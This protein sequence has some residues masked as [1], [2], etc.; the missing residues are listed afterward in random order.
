MKL[1]LVVA[2]MAAVAACGA[3]AAYPT[4]KP[5]LVSA[6]QEFKEGRQSRL[7]AG[8]VG[9]WNCRYEGRDA[10][11]IWTQ[12]D[13]YI[14]RC[15]SATVCQ[16]EYKSTTYIGRFQ[17]KGRQVSFLYKDWNGVDVFFTHPDGNDW[18]AMPTRANDYGGSVKNPMRYQDAVKLHVTSKHRGVSTKWTCNRAP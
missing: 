7:P 12:M 3:A 16:R 4:N 14:E 17:D 5:V 8:F 11:M 1:R 10:T 2:T 18:Q 15:T 13:R 9:T 6:E